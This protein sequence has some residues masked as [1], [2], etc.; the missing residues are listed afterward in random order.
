[1]FSR[2][3]GFAELNEAIA[4]SFWE[5]LLTQTFTS[6]VQST[7]DFVEPAIFAWG[8]TATQGRDYGGDGKPPL[9]V[10]LQL[11]VADR[12]VPNDTTLLLGQAFE[13]RQT[14]PTTF[15]TS[16]L[17]IAE[18]DGRGSGLTAFDYGVRATPAGSRPAPND[19][20][21]RLLTNDAALRQIDAFLQP[22]GRLIQPCDGACDPE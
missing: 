11:G 14:V 13:A 21:A 12:D 1:M 9:T 4:G 6:I 3:G 10:V 2:W 16:L 7:F 15:R 19:V 8:A 17:D 22:D 20:H 5:P 18:S